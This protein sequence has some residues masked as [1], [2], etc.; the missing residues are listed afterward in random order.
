MQA[1][2]NSE[3]EKRL[4]SGGAPMLK[5][6]KQS[7][8]PFDP[9]NP[10]SKQLRD[11]ILSRV[12]QREAA[13]PPKT[14]DNMPDSDNACIRFF[15]NY[16]GAK[17]LSHEPTKK[18]KRY[19]QGILAEKDLTDPEIQGGLRIFQKYCAAANGA[20]FRIKIV[21]NTTKVQSLFSNNCVY[22]C[23]TIS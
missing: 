11:R 10:S 20:G 16:K 9:R 7:L 3:L 19:C 15:E 22:D 14:R 23:S 4:A 6:K 17:S 8:L 18:R 12:N 5:V 13:G 21:H 1:C 2:Y